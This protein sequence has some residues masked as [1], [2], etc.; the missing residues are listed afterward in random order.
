ML[1]SQ[2]GSLQFLLVMTMAMLFAGATGMFDVG[3]DLEE[4][5]NNFKNTS[6]NPQFPDRVSTVLDLQ[7]DRLYRIMA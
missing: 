5:A 7:R 2:L 4:E 3:L 6:A 1:W